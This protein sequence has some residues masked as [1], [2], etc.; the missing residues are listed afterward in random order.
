MTDYKCK[1]CRDTGK[2]YVVTAGGDEVLVDCECQKVTTFP[3]ERIARLQIELAQ[4]KELIE[5]KDEALTRLEAEFDA[6]CNAE[7][8]RQVR[9]DNNRLQAEVA[10]LTGCLETANSNHEHFEREWY[11]R[12]DRIAELEEGL[13]QAMVWMADDGCDCGTSEA[14]SCA[15]C[16]CNSL[17]G[18]K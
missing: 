4:A 10:R 11:L 8:L 14:G 7:E 12:G 16:R 3:L 5:L 2:F 1:R 6:T 15:L 13:N 18:E 9:E 17:L